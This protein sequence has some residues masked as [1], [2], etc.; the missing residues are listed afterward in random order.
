M[1]LQYRSTP[2]YPKC[3]GHKGQF[4]QIIFQWTYQNTFFLLDFQNYFNFS[5]NGTQEISYY[6]VQIHSSGSEASLCRIL[7]VPYIIAISLTC[8]NLIYTLSCDME[9]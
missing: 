5:L 6:G 3:Q 7:P 2:W 1:Q 4:Y 8:Y 9:C